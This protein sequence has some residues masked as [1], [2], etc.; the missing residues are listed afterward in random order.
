[1]REV[2]IKRTLVY[3]TYLEPDSSGQ[4]RNLSCE[5]AFNW[6]RTEIS[7]HAGE[8]ITKSRALLSFELTL[9]SQNSNGNS[10]INTSS[11]LTEIS[12][13]PA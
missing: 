11:I 9:L 13:I 5:E 8:I 4:Q 10:N 1:M 2:D 7:I 6:I 12:R 3:D